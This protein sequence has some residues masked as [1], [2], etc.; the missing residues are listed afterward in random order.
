MYGRLEALEKRQRVMMQQITSQLQD[1]D[2]QVTLLRSNHNERLDDC[3]RHIRRQSHDIMALRERIS[4]IG[5]VLNHYYHSHYHII[6]QWDVLNNM[7]AMRHL[8][9][10]LSISIDWMMIVVQ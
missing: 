7:C 9:I 10:S 6:T 3:D 1:N 4:H 5:S 2:A 8:S